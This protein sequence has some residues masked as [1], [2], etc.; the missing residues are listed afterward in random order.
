M[1]L[2]SISVLGRPEQPWLVMIHG[3]GGSKNMWKRQIE[4][5][6]DD[7]NLLVVELPGHG[8]CPCSMSASREA[9]IDTVAM[10]VIQLLLEKDIA[11]ANFLCVSLGSLVM[12]AIV[13]L[14]PEMVGSV[15][16]C[17]AIFGMTRSTK[18]ILK[19]G[20]LLKFFLPFTVM[21]QL[22]ANILMPRRSHKK[23]RVF[24]VDE[25]KK[26]GRAEF[27]RWYS[28][29][30]RELNLLKNNLSLFRGIHTLVVMGSEDYV[31]LRKSIEA[32]IDYKNKVKLKFIKK[33]GHV[34][35][36]Q[37]WREFNRM[38]GE[39]FLPAAQSAAVQ[40]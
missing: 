40:R 10:S 38:A 11:R 37:K 26:L 15:L 13:R 36:L 16:M 18:W 7:F 19:L 14:C 23:S 39:F 24:L 34:C 29:L 35:C 17:G 20:N 25:C 2:S 1:N 31:F 33:C 21:I 32:L 3:F 6:R 8:A 28:I 12:A 5:F 30:V 4:Y 27:I 9:T 22:L